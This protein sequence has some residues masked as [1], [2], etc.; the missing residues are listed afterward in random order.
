MPLQLRSEIK[1]NNSLVL[2]LE[3]MAMPEPAEDEVVIRIEAS[4]INP[5][6]LGLLF[7]GADMSSAKASGTTDRPVITVDLSPQLMATVAGRIDQ[8]LPVGNE[9]AGV[10]V[11]AG[12][13]DR[14]QSLLGKTVSV[15]GGSMFSQYRALRAVQCL[16]MPS[17]ISA[18]E[19]AS[20]FVN[21][22]TALGIVETMRTEGHKALVNTAAASNLGQ[23]LNKLCIADGVDL[24]NVVRKPE[25]EKILRELGAKFVVNSAAEN[26][27]EDLAE[28]LVSTGA[29]IAFDAT[30][31]GSLASAILSGMEI[32]ANKAAKSYS[33][34]GSTVHKQ[35]YIYGGLD[36]STTI[37]ERNYGMAWGVG[38]WL[39]TPFL[40]RIGI[41]KLR[42]LQARVASEIKT[43][44]KS[45]YGCEVSLAEALSLESINQYRVQATGAKFLINPQKP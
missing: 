39:L 45:D 33:R 21:P 43:T 17:G 5:S 27:K 10:V 11:A 3:E 1:S 2:S 20:G 9:G 32:A 31:G 41:T 30:G 16:V 15:A 4:P 37:L 24:V 35:V 19:A 22:L 8:A 34:Y 42:E 25:Q 6:D 40:Q 36:C 13:S 18:A 7:G 28:A 29:T 12:D 23:I 38:G 14:A 26:F 44:F